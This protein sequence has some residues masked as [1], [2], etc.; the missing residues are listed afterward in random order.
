MG[1]NVKI[2]KLLGDALS[3]KGAPVFLVVIIGFFCRRWFR[4]IVGRGWD[5]SPPGRS[6]A[7]G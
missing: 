3:P 5:D 7:E 4:F 6:G 1:A 2:R